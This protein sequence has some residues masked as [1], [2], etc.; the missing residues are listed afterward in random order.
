[1]TQG[2]MGERMDGGGGAGW[3]KG[4]MGGGGRA[5]WGRGWTGWGVFVLFNTKF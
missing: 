3:G 5:G 4:W 1:M 2:W